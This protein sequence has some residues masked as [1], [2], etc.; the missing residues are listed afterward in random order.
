MKESIERSG[1][2][3][4][5]PKR[6]VYGFVLLLFFAAAVIAFRGVGRWLVREDPLAHADIIVVL[7]GS[8]PSRAEEAAGYFAS[9]YAKEVWVS[10]PEGPA[11]EL[12][13]MGIQYSGEE[14]YSR[15]VLIHL[16]VPP[17]AVQILPDP[18]IN[19][20][21]EIEEVG[22]RMRQMGKTSAIIVTSPQHTRRVRALWRKLVGEN[23]IAIVR[24]VSDDPFDRDHWWRTTQDALAVVR[25]ILGLMNVWAG[26]PIRP[27]R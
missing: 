22:R 1:K 2:S 12:K 7:S 13:E 3:G 5:R 27:A 25:E 17:T 19:T 15:Q 16:H 11:E 21:E 4:K 8:M 23:P 18:T 26:L 24:A 6:L 10:R 14:D 20:E 9:G